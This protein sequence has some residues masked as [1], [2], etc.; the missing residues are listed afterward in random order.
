MRLLLFFSLFFFALYRVHPI[1][2]EKRTELSSNVYLVFGWR[3]PFAI[4]TF[5]NATKEITTTRITQHNT[6]LSDGNYELRFIVCLPLLLFFNVR[7]AAS[8]EVCKMV[9][10]VVSVYCTIRTIATQ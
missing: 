8:Y 2:S 7:Q 9:R 1:E 6:V 10:D 5:A 3:L 4:E